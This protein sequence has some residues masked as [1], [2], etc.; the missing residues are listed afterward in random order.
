M[1]NLI[2]YCRYPEINELIAD[3]FTIEASVTKKGDDVSVTYSTSKERNDI[4]PRHASIMKPFNS[5]VHATEE[6]QRNVTSAKEISFPEILPVVFR[7]MVSSEEE[8]TEKVVILLYVR[9]EIVPR[10]SA[11]YVYADNIAIE[12]GVTL[13]AIDYQVASVSIGKL[14]PV[15]TLR[16]ID[17]PAEE[18]DIQLLV[19]KNPSAKTE[20]TK[21]SI[22]LH[23]VSAQ[24][25]RIVVLM[26]LI[27]IT[28][29]SSA[30]TPSRSIKEEFLIAP[31]DGKS[32]TTENKNVPQ[33]DVINKVVYDGMACVA[34]MSLEQL[35]VFS[36]AVQKAL[37][38]RQGTLVLAAIKVHKVPE[39]SITYQQAKLLET[40]L[41]RNPLPL[42]QTRELI[43]AIRAVLR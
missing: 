39:D 16:S 35:E 22:I 15:I 30:K 13:Q 27:Q 20:V 32:N 42:I 34:A 29:L 21:R 38:I 1:S 37:V 4:S 31:E 9:T 8:P 26:D 41:T 12:N 10:R 2:T 5:Y 7:H 23:E 19:T 25:H 3:S 28:Q 17:S 11:K 24:R 18:E 43:E 6:R 40:Y 33:V 14:V 36:T